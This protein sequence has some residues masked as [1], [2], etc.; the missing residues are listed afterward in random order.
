[1][2]QLKARGWAE[3][4]QQ[5]VVYFQGVVCVYGLCDLFCGC[6]FV[7]MW[8]VFVMVSVQNLDLS[9]SSLEQS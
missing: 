1:M 5:E 4:T 6:R 7:T 9:S 8:D 2:E 3:M